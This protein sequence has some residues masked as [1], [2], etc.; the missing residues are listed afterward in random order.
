MWLGALARILPGSERTVIVGVSSVVLRGWA[1]NLL[2]RV[3]LGE[4]SQGRNLRAFAASVQATESGS[5]APR[6][7]SLPFV[8]A[9]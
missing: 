6:R 7:P 8:R 5:S 3:C 4:G 9:H 2:V 1:P